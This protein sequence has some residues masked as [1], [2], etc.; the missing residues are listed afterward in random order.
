[1]KRTNIV[2]SGLALASLVIGGLPTGTYAQGG[3]GA[4]QFN[5]VQSSDNLLITLDDT[6][7]TALLGGESVIKGKVKNTSTGPLYNVGWTVRLPEGVD[8]LGATAGP[9]EM[10]SPKATVLLYPDGH[11]HTLVH[12][13]NAAD[14]S[15][16]EEIN[17]E[18]R[19]KNKGPKSDEQPPAQGK[20]KVYKLEESFRATAWAQGSTVASTLPFFA[21][22][23]EADNLND[24]AWA[25]DD[26]S[27]KLKGIESKLKIEEQLNG[28]TL[29]GN[30]ENQRQ[31]VTVSLE[32]TGAGLIELNKP[33][34]VDLDPDWEIFGTCVK[35]GEN[36]FTPTEN[37]VRWVNSP[38]PKWVLDIP[39]N[40]FQWSPENKASVTFE[41]AALDKENS[42]PAITNSPKVNMARLGGDGT[43]GGVQDDVARKDPAYS[44]NTGAATQNKK[45]KI[46]ASGS[47]RYNHPWNNQE[48]QT[49]PNKDRVDFD[50]PE[51][52]TQIQDTS[53]LLTTKMI[54]VAAYQNEK[55]AIKTLI[56]KNNE[57]TPLPQD[58]RI[59][60]TLPE[61][62]CPVVKGQENCASH[63]D[64]ITIDRKVEPVEGSPRP[65]TVTGRVTKGPDNKFKIVIDAAGIDPGTSNTQT[66]AFNSKVLGTA[67]GKPVVNGKPLET[68]ALLEWHYPNERVTV[69]AKAELPPAPLDILNTVAFPAA[70]DGSCPAPMDA[71]PTLEDRAKLK[72]QAENKR[73]AE[74]LTR[75][76]I[77]GKRR[78]VGTD[79]E[80]CFQ[81]L[82]KFPDGIVT[83]DPK[84]NLFLPPEAELSGEPVT[85]LKFTGTIAGQAQIEALSNIDTA[86]KPVPTPDKRTPLTYKLGASVSDG[87]LL[88]VVYKA[89]IKNASVVYPEKPEV[90]YDNLAKLS[91]TDF[92]GGFAN[93]RDVAS[94]E[95]INPVL[96]IAVDRPNIQY[97]KRKSTQKLVYTVTNVGDTPVQAGTKVVVKLPEGLTCTDVALGTGATQA[98]CVSG[99][100]SGQDPKLLSGSYLLVD[101]VKPIGAKNP[102][103]NDDQATFDLTVTIPNTHDP[104]TTYQL[105]AGIVGYKMQSGGGQPAIYIPKTNAYCKP[106]ASGLNEG[107]QEQ[108][109]KECTEKIAASLYSVMNPDQQIGKTLFVGANKASGGLS[110][111]TLTSIQTLAATIAIEGTT[112]DTTNDLP[113]D[114]KIVVPGEKGTVRVKITPPAS[115][116][117]AGSPEVLEGAQ[118]ANSGD[119]SV[120]LVVKGLK[121]NDPAHISTIEQ[122]KDAFENTLTSA[123]VNR[124]GIT[125]QWSAGTGTWNITVPLKR[126]PGK[127]K[128]VD[129][130][131]VFTTTDKN[132]DVTATLIYKP[133]KLT[134]RDTRTAQLNQPPAAQYK[135]VSTRAAATYTRK[136]PAITVTKQVTNPVTNQIAGNSSVT[137]AVTIRNT[138][139]VTA[140]ELTVT[141]TL[142]ESFRHQ[143]NLTSVVP[144]GGADTGLA[145]K[146]AWTLTESDKVGV[147]PENSEKFSLPKGASVTLTYVATAPALVTAAQAYT[148]RV[149]VPWASQ[150]NNPLGNLT[151]NQQGEATVQGNAIVSATTIERQH[152]R[153]GFTDGAIQHGDVVRTTTR[154]TIPGRVKVPNLSV[155]TNLS[156]ATIDRTNA[157]VQVTCPPSSGLTCDSLNL[158]TGSSTELGVNL[159]NSEFENNTDDPITVDVTVSNLLV[160]DGNGPV[161][162]K[163]DAYIGATFPSNVGELKGMTRASDGS[164][165]AVPI[166]RPALQVMTEL[167]EGAG[168]TPVNAPIEP[169]TELTARVTLTNTGDGSKL[170]NTSVTEIINQLAAAGLTP[171]TAFNQADLS[172]RTVVHGTPVVIEIPL[173]WD[174]DKFVGGSKLT[175]E[176]SINATAKGQTGPLGAH[177]DATAPE[178]KGKDVTHTGT[179]TYTPK[180]PNPALTV[181]ITNPDGSPLSDQVPPL[182]T[183]GNKA[184]ITF[185]PRVNEGAGFN[186]I[187]CVKASNISPDEAKPHALGELK[188]IDAAPG[189]TIA[190]PAT[191]CGSGEIQVNLPDPGPDGTLPPVVFELTSANTPISEIVHTEISGTL[192][193]DS[194]IEGGGGTPGNGI[195]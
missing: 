12:W 194:R 117:A 167:L 128:T 147:W 58:R 114:K 191:A 52:S 125:S 64:T 15:Q 150:P 173:D 32:R 118:F 174:K 138:S 90:V 110:T 116:D 87:S 96:M 109:D 192:K 104:Q 133:L 51:I 20:G 153:H 45:V 85:A 43:E 131:D 22:F 28:V 120:V 143:A 183:L 122:I 100:K 195:S 7:A 8:Y 111:E 2:M 70:A 73:L 142:P 159:K 184:K 17:F 157:Q 11:T 33:I 46:D 68:K 166:K 62:E 25:K 47:A 84:L 31:K 146:T 165:G 145:A 65:D 132:V 178:T 102:D 99:D 3:S 119:A 79:K 10:G 169:G 36:C 105:P 170:Y 93:A 136:V 162:A 91:Y 144:A 76:D 37:D 35:L 176:Q 16:A 189:V 80:L 81:V 94:Y 130:T 186:P 115:N 82:M 88:S 92:D 112:K 13:G 6:K 75:P 40:K 149:Q 158:L 71:M 19:V 177:Q 148:N 61:Q 23:G 21:E 187:M 107:Q 152:D 55:L 83:N 139:E 89:K 127:E 172:N 126:I 29:R 98:E 39:A 135:A 182:L 140:H 74:E 101:L 63:N 168:N 193:V 108:A 190:D 181:G 60:V 34:S 1:M 9:G 26:Q 95:F 175:G 53:V 14:I 54:D 4:P 97:Q 141:D 72:D 57:Y 188:L 134:H 106:Q 77:W 161:T 30:K 129:L 179:M 123:V 50:I 185:T 44:N 78:K 49:Y 137:Y 113:N 154:I 41:I 66:F 151:G 86:K 69:D 27:V 18:I 163:G 171:T 121:D 38:K 164:T 180:Y 156:G 56:V 5:N 59:E 124:A 24:P 103:N 42:D 160:T 48:P 67:N 155:L